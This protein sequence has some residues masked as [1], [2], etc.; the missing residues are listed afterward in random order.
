MGKVRKRRRTAGKTQDDAPV[1][2]TPPMEIICRE[3]KA[4]VSSQAEEKRENAP[5]RDGT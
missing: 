1:P 5:G 4:S 3:G 2:I